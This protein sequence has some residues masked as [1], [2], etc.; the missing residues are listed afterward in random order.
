MEL[1]SLVACD[2]QPPQ[3]SRIWKKIVDDSGGDGVAWARFLYER[4]F[5]VFESFFL[6][7]GRLKAGEEG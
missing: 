3:N 4:G 6:E 5:S 2:I 1:A 7:R